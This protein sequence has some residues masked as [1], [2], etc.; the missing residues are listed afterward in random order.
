MKEKES[1]AINYFIWITIGLIIV[2]GGWILVGNFNLFGNSEGT[3]YSVYNNYVIYEVND[4]NVLRYRVE[5]V[6]NNG[7]SYI[8]TFRN[9]PP[10]LLELNYD[11]NV[12]EKILYKD[13]SLKKDKIYFS[14]DPSMDGSEILASG[15]L[16]QILGTSDAGIFQTPVVISSSKENNNPDFPIKTCNDSTKEIGVIELRYGEPKLYSKGECVIIQG[17]SREDFIKYNDLLS[18]MLLGVI[19]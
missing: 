17:N 10:D 14:Y 19:E 4:G 9:Y 7:K 1:K 13:S 2:V 11:I 8:H 5:A 16:I 6:A 12:R 18:Y 15:T 3:S